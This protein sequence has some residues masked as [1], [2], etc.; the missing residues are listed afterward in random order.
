[1]AGQTH[2][3]SL[4]ALVLLLVAAVGL[5]TDA[6]PNT[7][8]STAGPPTM[9]TAYGG[10]GEYTLITV[11]FPYPLQALVTDA[12]DRPVSNAEVQFSAPSSGAGA[13]FAPAGADQLII[14]TDASGI[15]TAYIAANDQRGGYYAEARV[16]GVSAP[17]RFLLT[18][19]ASSGIWYIAPDGDNENSCASPAEACATVLGPQ[20]KEQFVSGDTIR[21]AAGVYRPPPSPYSPTIAS[22]QRMLILSGGWNR[23]F[24]AVEGLSTLTPAYPMQGCIG[25]SVTASAAV[26]RFVIEGCFRSPDEPGYVVSGTGV[27]NGSQL[28][29]TESIV[30]NHKVWGVGAGI[31]NQGRLLLDRVLVYG[32]QAVYPT[33][34][35]HGCRGPAGAGIYNGGVLFLSKSTV[36][37]NEVYSEAPYPPGEGGGIWSSG[38]LLIDKSTIVGNRA[39]T[40]GGIWAES[41]IISNSI[42]ADNSGSSPTNCYGG[43]LSGGFNVVSQFTGGGVS[44]CFSA[45]G[46]G[47]QFDMRAALGELEDNGGLTATMALLPGSPAINAGNPAGCPDLFNAAD[48]SDQRRALQSGRCDAGAFEASIHVDVQSTSQRKAGDTVY[49][50]VTLSNLGNNIDLPGVSLTNVMTTAV[51]FVPN[52]LAVS[53]GSATVAGHTI[54]WTGTVPGEKSLRLSYAAVIGSSLAPGTPI[55]NTTDARWGTARSADTDSFLVASRI[56]TVT[57]T[58]PASCP[59]TPTPAPAFSGSLPPASSIEPRVSHCVDDAHERIDTAEVFYGSPVVSTGGGPGGP[60]GIIQYTGGFLFRD[61]RLPRYAQITSA[62]LRVNAKY[63]SGVP[64]AQ[65]ITGDNRGN[66]DDFTPYHLDLN[67]RPRTLARV[68]WTLTTKLYGWVDSPQIATIVQEIV[69]RGDWQPGNNLAILIDPGEGVD[70]YADWWAFDQGPSIG[71]RL[72]VSYDGLIEP[73]ATATPSQTPIASPSPTATPTPTPSPSATPTPTAM[74]PLTPTATPTGTPTATMT[75]T[76]IPAAGD[77]AG[78]AWLDANGDGV[79]DAR[80]AGLADVRIELLRDGISTDAVTTSDDGSYHFPDLLPGQYT[81]REVQPAWLRFSTTPDEVGVEVTNGQETIVAFGD[82]NGLP[83]WL[84]LIVR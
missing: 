27:S 59:V 68:P 5:P 28:R 6:A 51:T 14:R 55:T 60:I 65:I 29:L 43:L 13:R 15:A 41:G 37:E 71:V 7:T 40:G 32:N 82:W 34:C 54:T 33:Y 77:I 3:P 36:Y 2:T 39:A 35:Y 49:Y 61:V 4:F 52:S 9:V 63:Q 11:P 45:P 26:E 24:T 66:A 78:T 19:L 44:G 38:T 56:G 10:D 79:H 30:R 81:V 20:F 47:D 62:K 84:P 8:L 76:P 75:L 70:K 16:A 69:N 72:S 17:A 18:N 73:T 48:T 67:H 23:Q 64:L 74:P 31:Y 57:P 21:A 58:P 50:D 12:N 25:L 42:L 80:E 83:A 53:E 1:M 22:I 46:P